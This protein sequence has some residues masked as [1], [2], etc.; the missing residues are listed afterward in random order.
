MGL[1]DSD[2]LWGV[3]DPS[4]LA[5]ATHD[6]EAQQDEE[7]TLLK[8]QEVRFVMMRRGERADVL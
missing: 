6:F 4:G 3:D 5:R 1:E 8:G 7:L 2:T